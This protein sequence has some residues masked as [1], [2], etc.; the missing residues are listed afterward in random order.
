MSRH[1]KKRW[2]L[3]IVLAA[4]I[5]AAVAVVEVRYEM[6]R[7]LSVNLNTDGVSYVTYFSPDSGSKIIQYD[8][9]REIIDS[10]LENI[11]GEYTYVRRA[12]TAGTDG[13]NPYSLSL[14]DRDGNL[15]DTI[16]YRDKCVWVK[17]GENEYYCYEK[18]GEA[19]DLTEF[20]KF[21]ENFGV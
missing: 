6:R 9:N 2:G 15:L 18:N 13:G 14:Y 20:E 11:A 16:Y 17:T 10:A 7:S 4:V 21:M 5:A 19:L 1:A 3:G 8:K 12:S